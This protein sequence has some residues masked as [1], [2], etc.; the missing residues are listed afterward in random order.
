MPRVDYHSQPPGDPHPGD[1]PVFS[2]RFGTPARDKAERARSRR[3]AAIFLGFVAVL[4]VIGF[5]SHA[6][7]GGGISSTKIGPLEIGKATPAEARL[8]FGLSLDVWKRSGG[9]APIRFQGELW[10]YGC[11]ADAYPIFGVPC[12]TLFGF[13]GGRLQ[14]V[15]TVNP[16]FSTH[17]G[18]RIG[19]TVAQAVKRNHGKWSGWKVSCPL[20]TFPSPKGIVF[21]ARVFRNAANSGGV[22]AGFYLST[23]PGSFGPCGT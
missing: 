1:G 22:V 17:A 10:R 19:A 5:F 2:G 14:S 20:V 13:A 16:Q 15:L 11:G 6:V 18:T 3:T 23:V 4:F 9:T 21:A 7:G 8:H 12:R